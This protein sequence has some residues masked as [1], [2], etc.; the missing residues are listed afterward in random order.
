[1]VKYRRSRI[2][3]GTYFFTVTL[4]DRRSD[5]LL[6]HVETFR[7]AYTKVKTEH[8]FKTLSYVILPDHIHCLWQ[9]PES[10]SNY[11][12][13]WQ[14]IKKGFTSRLLKKGMALSRNKHGEYN[15]WQRRYWEHTIRDEQDYENHI[16][17]IHYNPV[18]H[19][20]VKRAQDWPHSSFLYYVSRGVLPLDWGG[21]GWS[22]KAYGERF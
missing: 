1:M 5:I 12:Q 11:S 8:P 21:V 13:R 2:S 18:K 17:Y 16:N 10:D 19:G 22:D 14:L 7:T 9:L 3:G 4:K 6:G 20:L 15:L